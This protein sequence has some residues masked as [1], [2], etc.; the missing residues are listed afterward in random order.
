MIMQN[1]TKF[2]RTNL[3]ALRS[4]LQ[5]VLNKFGANLEFEIGGITFSETE[6][7]LKLTAKVKGA[8]TYK[9]LVLESRVKALGIVM[10]K[11]DLKLVRYDS[12]KPKFPFIYEK[13][14]KLFKTSELGAKMLFAA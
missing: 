2:D 1:V 4:E 6:A 12:R 5:A 8:V 9:D 14:G 3:K 11:N 10:E 13:G 7:A